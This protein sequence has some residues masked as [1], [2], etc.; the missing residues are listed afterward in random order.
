M[1]SVCIK[2]S[3]LK[4]TK[5]LLEKLNN[6]KFNDTYFS[7]K[8][9]RIYYNIIIHFK[10]NNINLF[11]V[12]L[13]KL[14]SAFII[15]LFEEN[16]TKS[17]IKSEYFYFDNLEQQQILNITMQDLYDSEEAI[18][19]DSNRIKIINDK[20]YEYL[21]YNHSIIL[22]GFIKFRIRNYL[23]AL[24]EQ[25][26][27]S[28]NK[29]IIEK[30]YTEFISLLRLYVNSEKSSCSEVHLIYHNYKP[31]LLDENKNIININ[32]DALNVKYLSD[33]TFSSN[34]YTLN[35]LLNIIPNKINVHL[36]DEKIDEFINTLKL[37]FEERVIFCSNCPICDIYKKS[38]SINS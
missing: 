38:P 13:S 24:L 6:L 20:L 2:L 4:T 10:G 18:N 31:L 1:K 23:E 21:N 37:V 15:D 28:V 5:Y 34:D 8:K 17:L 16:I 36:I 30:E 29:Y 27:K 32:E 26:D 7:C 35:T 19:S 3:S 11:L 9:F 25:I 12:Q 33:I 14:L 22:K